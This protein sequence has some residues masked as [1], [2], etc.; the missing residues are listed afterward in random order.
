[1]DK[2]GYFHLKKLGWSS[3][4]LSIFTWGQTNIPTFFLLQILQFLFDIFFQNAMFPNYVKIKVRYTFVNI[5]S[6][7]FSHTAKDKNTKNNILN[8]N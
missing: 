6:F 7:K 5:N 8:F 3:H 2:L 1:M 4:D